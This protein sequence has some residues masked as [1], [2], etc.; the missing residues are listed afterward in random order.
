MG[1]Q[2]DYRKAF[3]QKIG[4]GT[5]WDQLHQF[6]LQLRKDFPQG[7]TSYGPPRGRGG[8]RR[9]NASYGFS[10]G[11]SC[12]Q[13]A[14]SSPSFRDLGRTYYGPPR[15]RGGNRG[16]ANAS[17]SFSLER[18]GTHDAG[19]SPDFRGH[20]PRGRGDNY[21][22]DNAF[23]GFSFEQDGTQDAGPSPVFRGYG[24]RGRGGNRGRRFSP[25]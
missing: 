4:D 24:P 17:Y 15:G 6:Y 11:R 3:W 7:G 12:T 14:G 25:Y 18:D 8:N 22:R 23:Y 16:L 10:L 20:G 1:S 5:S 13:D 2:G 21:G 19:P 9:H